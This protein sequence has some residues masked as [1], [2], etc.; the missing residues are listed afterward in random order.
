NHITNHLRTT[1][2][3]TNTTPSIASRGNSNP[4]KTASH[5]PQSR[6]AERRI[7]ETEIQP[8][9]VT[10]NGATSAG[11]KKAN[12][13][14][15]PNAEANGLVRSN[16]WVLDS[17]HRKA[18]ATAKNRMAHAAPTMAVREKLV[19]GFDTP[20]AMVSTWVFKILA[21]WKRSS[22]LVSRARRT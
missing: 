18:G 1:N 5:K 7:C 14:N 15:T 19:S 2:H 11:T 6:S 20:D 12:T 13:L 3:N 17:C 4:S 16:S 22:G 21:C 10:P 8:S 9:S